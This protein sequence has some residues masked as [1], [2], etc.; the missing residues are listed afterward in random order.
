VI[1]KPVQLLAHCPTCKQYAGCEHILQEESL[2][3]AESKGKTW[4]PAELEVI[5]ATQ[6]IPLKVVAEALN[7]TYYA[8]SKTR[9]LVKKGILKT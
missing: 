8:T 1:I 2:P 6:D 9:S 7:R 4:T 5:K 3:N